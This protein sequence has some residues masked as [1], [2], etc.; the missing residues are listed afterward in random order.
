MDDDGVRQMMAEGRP[1][2]WDNQPPLLHSEQEVYDAFWELGTCRYIGMSMGA[3]PFTAID[4]Y[5]TRHGI[6]GE[7]FE[8]FNYLI[9]RLDRLWIKHQSE[10]R[11][12]QPREVT[13]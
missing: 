13:S 8:R 1:G 2:F 10:K 9:R 3:I 6:D 4:A 12:T 7:E 11:E 5:S